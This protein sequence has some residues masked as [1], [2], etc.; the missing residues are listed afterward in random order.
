M[1]INVK[2]DIREATRFVKEI[3]QKGIDRA[4]A[5]AMNDTT[6]T[7][8]AEGAREIKKAHPAL[9][10]G[11]IKNNLSLVKAF[12]Q[13]LRASV[14]T[15]GKPLSLLLYNARRARGVVTAKMGQRQRPVVYRGRRA[16]IVDSLGG[17][18][19]VRKHGKGREIRKF[20]G[21]SLPGVFRAQGAKFKAMAAKRFPT[22]FAGRMTFEIERAKRSAGV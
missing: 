21:P 15:T 19:F 18:V 11:D 7:M 14:D 5:R 20:R 1:R 12:P 8:R 22:A 4:T 16:F 13:R 9:K 17:E 6:T 2:A 3:D 10:I